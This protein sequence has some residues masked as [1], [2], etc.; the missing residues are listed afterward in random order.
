M[1]FSTDAVHA[2]QDPDPRTGSVILPIHQTS[3]YQ[4]DGLGRPR[5]GYEYGR[6]QNPTREALE[7]NLTRLENGADAIAFSSG[8][9]A[10]QS[11]LQ[12]LQAG[13]HVVCTENIYGGTYRLGAGPAEWRPALDH[14]PVG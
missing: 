5:L 14:Q 3:T 7:A 9:A 1:G 8:M 2:G 13:D 11:V 6:S 4:Q 10:I 12:L